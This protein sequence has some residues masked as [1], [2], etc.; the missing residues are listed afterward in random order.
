MNKKPYITPAVK[1]YTVEIAKI[2]ESSI[3]GV[4]GDAGIQMGTEGETPGTADSR[5][6]SM[7]WDDEDD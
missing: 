5:C 6:G 3:N 4:G 2:M 7:F 1:L